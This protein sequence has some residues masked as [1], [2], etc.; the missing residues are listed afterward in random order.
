MNTRSSGK[1]H[2]VDVSE[3]SGDLG[4]SERHGLWC[5]F[6]SNEVVGDER[7]LICDHDHSHC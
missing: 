7:V 3:E 4:G 2:L 1:S 5:C 6:H